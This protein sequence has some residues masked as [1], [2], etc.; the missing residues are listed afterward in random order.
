MALPVLEPDHLAVF[1]FGP[2][3]GELILARVPPD[4]WLVVDGCA[5]QGG[6]AQQVLDHYQA[7]P[8]LIVLTHPHDDHSKGLT[9]VIVR[10]T[11]RDR[12]EEWPRIGMV[13]P[14]GG[15][16]A[17]RGDDLAAGVTQQVIAA[18]ESRWRASPE[19]KW[20]MFS[21][22]V[23]PLGE[24]TV[25]VLSPEATVRK[26]K[27]ALWS[28]GKWFDKNVISSALLLE[29]RGCRV[30][31]GSDLV[32]VPRDGW[33]TCLT[34]DPGLGDHDLFKVPHHGADKALHAE[35]L[36]PGTRVPEPLRVIAPFS[37]KSLPRFTKGKGVERIHQQAGT[38]YLTGLPRAH[39]S[40][41][42]A[43]EER[44]LA[45]L[46]RHRGLVFHPTTRGFPDCFVMVSF[47][48]G[49]GPPAVLQGPGSIR[50]L[51]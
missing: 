39:A 4:T 11:P 30:V 41:S 9:E 2:G 23:E 44:S 19:C 48:P 49:G 12:M 25:R 21:G 35:I 37:I 32:E 36:R 20:E 22:D 24:A 3:L 43:V 5:S 34:L 8:R 17:A 26:E 28:R 50:V 33:T 42:G 18:V 16:G 13:L 14:P 46:A 7:T 1:V 38:T 27:L 10:A 6:Y 40:Q 31:L 51:R 29:W 15:G 45:E 47:A